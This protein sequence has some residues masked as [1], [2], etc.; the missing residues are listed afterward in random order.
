[1]SQAITEVQYSDLPA[2]VSSYFDLFGAHAGRVAF[3][4]P[5]LL[6]VDTFPNRN[7]C[8]IDGCRV[9]APSTPSPF[10]FSVLC[11]VAPWRTSLP[12]LRISLS[13]QRENGSPE[14]HPA[15]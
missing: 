15:Q 5:K 7:V 10:P 1:M 14:G 9:R 4:I 6:I 3:R 12:R 2:D 11:D 8:G 13:G